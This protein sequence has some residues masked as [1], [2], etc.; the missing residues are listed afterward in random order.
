MPGNKAVD[1]GRDTTN[2]LKMPLHAWRDIL[3]RTWS[4]VGSDNVGLIA[5]G[6]AFYSFLAAVPLL[7]SCVLTY[8]LIA[9]PATVSNH[10]G[11][12]FELLPRD[13]ASLLGDQVLAI[14]QTAAEK[15]GLGLAVALSLAIYG[16][17]NGA[18]AIVTALNV[19]YDEAETRNI[20]K[21]RAL[22][23]L[24]TLGMTLVGVMTVLAIGALAFL[25]NL[26]PTAPNAIVIAI[27]I[28]F[29]ICAALAASTVVASI[30]RFGPDRRRARWR[31][32]TVGSAF[33]TIGWL[34][35]TLSFG[36]YVANFANYNATYGA[37]SA[38]VVLLMWIYFSAYLLIIG[39]E[40]N[41]EIEHQTTV[42][43][44]VGSPRP[45]GERR[46]SVADTVGASP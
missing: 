2:P 38:V 14:T 31:W 29:W 16:A 39:A 1:R 33:F 21:T 30:Y 36:F 7:A 3:W 11:I 12:L 6:V 4:E 23:L 17:M 35:M 5:A 22:A 37:L 10:L 46:A 32:L 42:D 25:E 20:F 43:T 41:S 34:I 24:I 26:I 13:A 28:A 27:R 15:T 18:G 9:D 45:M 19:A 40:L 8:G 44:T